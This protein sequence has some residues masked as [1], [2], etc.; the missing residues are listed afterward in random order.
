MPERPTA[1]IAEDE[2][3]LREAA[4]SAL[5]SLGYTVHAAE[6]GVVGLE[7]F[8]LHH[9]HLFAVLLDLKMPLMGGREAFESMR[10][11]DPEVP[12][13][14]CTGFGENEEVQHLLDLGAAGMLAKPYR[15][16][17]LAARLEGVMTP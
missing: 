16:A 8:R 14:V 12:V 7:A 3:L 6:N 5:E 9:Q 10:R 4:T 13:L 2:P 17:E 11:I 1:L 15:I